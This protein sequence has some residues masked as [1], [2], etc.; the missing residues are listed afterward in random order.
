MDQY[1]KYD[2]YIVSCYQ[3]SCENCC[4]C[5]AAG[6]DRSCAANRGDSPAQ[7]VHADPFDFKDSVT[8]VEGE[9]DGD[10]REDRLSLYRVF[11]EGKY[12]CEPDKRPAPR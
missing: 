5:D 10:I 7:S 8:F 4:N 9:L 11:G 2:R 3:R 12:K 6:S 1:Y